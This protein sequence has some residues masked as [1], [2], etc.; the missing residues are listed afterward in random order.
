MISPAIALALLEADADPAKAV[1]MA[2]YH[3]APRRYLGLSVPD[4]EGHVARW[5]AELDVT[6]R[7]A[8]AHGLWESDV[9]EARIAAAKLVTQARI[10][11]DE[12]AVWAEALAW[13][14]TF[15]SWALADHACKAIERRLWA[16]PDRLD[17]VETWVTD[18]TMWVRR[19]ALVATLPWTKNRHASTGEAA[20][21]ERILGWAAGLV[22]DRDWFIQKAIGWWLRSLSLHAPDHVRTFLEGPGAELKPF[23]RREAT[24]RLDG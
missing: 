5:R 19:A 23:A 17:T 12:A 20:A 15:D 7:V 22:A 9:H 18:P 13:V 4:V 24:R 21:R 2:A 11:E 3:K 8:L 1:E 16:F 6:G 10:R 14:P